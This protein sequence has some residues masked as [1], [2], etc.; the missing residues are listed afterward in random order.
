[1]ILSGISINDIK[2]NLLDKTR[3][4]RTL[5]SIFVQSLGE[6]KDGKQLL[7]FA[8]EGD[9]VEDVEKS[10]MGQ[11]NKLFDICVLSGK[12]NNGNVSLEDYFDVELVA[13]Q[14]NDDAQS[15]SIQ[16]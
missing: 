8:I 16:S 5:N 10:L 14:S 2:D 15:V 13:V 11:L 4:A 12:G 9:D 7:V 3:F 6:E 1:M